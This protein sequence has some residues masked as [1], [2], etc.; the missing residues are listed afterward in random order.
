MMEYVKRQKQK[1]EEEE[2]EEEG[3]MVMEYKNMGEEQGGGIGDG[4]RE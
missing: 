2:E 1:T 3:E 4:N